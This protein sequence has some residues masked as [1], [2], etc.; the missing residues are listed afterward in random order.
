M[1]SIVVAPER[2]KF[3]CSRERKN[4]LSVREGLLGPTFRIIDVDRFADGS[5]TVRSGD[6]E[7]RFQSPVD[8]HGRIGRSI[9]PVEEPV[10][11]V[12]FSFEV[13]RSRFGK[14]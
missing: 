7:H 12:N 13:I 6:H 8:V 5:G 4:C 1:A 2:E 14:G 3:E 9:N 10:D 11:M